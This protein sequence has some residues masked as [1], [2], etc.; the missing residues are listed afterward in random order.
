MHD[1]E[2]PPLWRLIFAFGIVFGVISF[3]LMFIYSWF[4]VAPFLI[5]GLAAY[6]F[7]RKLKAGA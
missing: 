3:G 1:G 7:T 2:L 6:F 4:F 5:I